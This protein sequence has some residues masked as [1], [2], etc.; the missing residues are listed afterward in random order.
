M[1]IYYSGSSWGGVGCHDYPEEALPGVSV[2][3]SFADIH[4]QDKHTL[5][6]FDKVLARRRAKD[7]DGSTKGKARD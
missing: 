6:R 2:L 7:R 5:K 4:K 1:I 3:L